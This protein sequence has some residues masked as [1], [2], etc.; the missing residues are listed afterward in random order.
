MIP[1]FCLLKPVFVFFLGICQLVFSLL[2]RNTIFK[3]WPVK[4]NSIH[5][6]P[7]RWIISFK[8]ARVHETRGS[9]V[10]LTCFTLFS[11]NLILRF[12]FLKCFIFIDY[13]LPKA[14]TLTKTFVLQSFTCDDANFF[15][16]QLPSK[17]WIFGT[18]L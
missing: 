16:I 10:K 9:P 3:T 15:R 6:N 8:H 7:K 2:Y 13:A 14:I 11:E 12:F 17:V 1:T 18:Q 5:A 4:T